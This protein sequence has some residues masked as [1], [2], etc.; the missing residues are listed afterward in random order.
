MR[1]PTLR[2]YCD[3]KIGY[4]SEVI[5]LGDHT[6]KGV[7]LFKLLH[8]VLPNP[9]VSDPY[10]SWFVPD[11]SEAEVET[12][13]QLHAGESDDPEVRFASLA[14]WYTILR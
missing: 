1:E 12:L 7:A 13:R 14:Y 10:A 6:N 2:R 9:L 3:Q 4:H 11:L 8:Q 5:D